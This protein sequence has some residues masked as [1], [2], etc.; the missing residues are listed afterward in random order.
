MKTMIWVSTAQFEGWAC[1]E[2]AWTFNPSG[3]PVGATLDQMKQNFERRRDKEFAS[4]VCAQH[5]KSK[6]EKPGASS[7][8]EKPRTSR[9][10]DDRT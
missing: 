3:P 5:P 6:G 1:S 7:V 4:H 2:C 8:T 10:F 9:G